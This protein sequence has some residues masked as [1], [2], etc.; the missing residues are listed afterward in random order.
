MQWLSLLWWQ[1]PRKMTD[2]PKL[3][4]KTG[5]N[6]R[7]F[8]VHRGRICRFPGPPPGKWPKWRFLTH[9]HRF[10]VILDL[11]L[12][13][14]IFQETAVHSGPTAL[15]KRRVLGEKMA[16]FEQK[17]SENGLKYTPKNVSGGWF[18]RDVHSFFVP[19]SLVYKER[20]I[21]KPILDSPTPQIRVHFLSFWA[22]N[23][24]PFSEEFGMI[25][26]WSWV[27]CIAQNTNIK[28]YQ[29]RAMQ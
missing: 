12:T 10:L 9:F 2:F 17:C 3:W 5:K 20:M 24:P 23:D 18:T 7:E 14:L 11:F 13:P 4:Q 16:L 8:A 19:V 6:P 29:L 1:V 26:Q 22:P 25:P 27:H 28:Q 21:G 15:K